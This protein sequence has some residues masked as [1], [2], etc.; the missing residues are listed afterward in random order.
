MKKK[1]RERHQN[2]Y[3]NIPTKVISPE[4]TSCSNFSDENF[5][6]NPELTAMAFSLL[7]NSY[8]EGSNAKPNQYFKI[9]NNL[10]PLRLAHMNVKSEP[11]NNSCQYN[12]A[13]RYHVNLRYHLT[14]QRKLYQD[15]AK[16]QNVFYSTFSKMSSVPSLNREN[17]LST[18]YYMPPTQTQMLSNNFNSLKHNKTNF[19]NTLVLTQAQNQ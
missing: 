7:P 14:I 9:E 19:V 5:K 12:T 10:E 6:S 13:N 15:Y 2:S 17:V 11:I 8:Q 18:S 4:S 1:L 16:L 3:V